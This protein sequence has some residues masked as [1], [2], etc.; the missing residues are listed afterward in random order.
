MKIGSRN[1]I[2]HALLS[3][4]ALVFFILLNRPEVILISGLGSVA[5]YPATG[6]VMALLLAIS[7][8]YA[9]LACLASAL[10]GFL[11]Y[12]QPFTS[13]GATIGAVAFG[14]SYAT[15]AHILRDRVRIDIRLRCRRDVACYLLVTTAAALIATFIGVACL[16]ADRSIPLKE[17]WLAALVWFLGDEI[18][19]LGVAPFLLIHVFPL[20]RRQLSTS[21]RPVELLI[22]KPSIW[23]L[24]E[25][26]IQGLSSGVV[27]W[28]MFGRPFGSLELFYLSF[29]PVIW[30]A[31][32][33]GIRRVVTILV[34]LN[35]GIALAMHFTP[36][37][38]GLL[39]KLGLLMFVISAAGL[40]L[41]SAVTERHRIAAELLERRTELQAVNGQLLI[42]K[43]AAEAA[44][45]AKSE[46]LANL[47]HEIRS[48]INGILGMAELV[49]DTELAP[50]QREYLELLKSSGESLLGV[51]NAILDFSKIEA[52]KLEL[53]AVE[54]NLRDVIDETI[55]SLAIQA[56]QKGLD[57]VYQVDANIQCVVG[58]SGL[59]RQI[60]VN[61]VGNAIK[62]T[63]QGEIVVLA[64][65]EALHDHEVELC[66]RVADTGIGIPLDKQSLIFEAFAQA[67]GSTTRT[68]GGT[69]LGLSI[70]SQLVALMGGRIW[71]ESTVSKGST[72]CFTVRMRTP[73]ATCASGNDDVPEL[74]DLPVLVVD[75]SSASRRITVD[76]C[77]VWGMRASGVGSGLEAL[78]A[79]RDAR[80]SGR[81]FRFVVIDDRM[82]GM[83]GFELAEHLRSDHDLGTVIML[84]TSNSCQAEVKRCQKLGIAAYVRKPI[85][86]SDMLRSILAALA[87]P[88]NQASISTT[89]ASPQK[90]PRTLRVLVAEDNPV[91]QKTVVG[92][93]KKMGHSARVA[94]N[95]QEALALLA[96]EAFDLVLMDVQ[97]PLMD[98][99]TAS[100]LIREHEKGSGS[101]VPIIAM[102]AHAMKTYEQ[103]CLEAGMD[104]YL[105]K[106]AN[107]RQL[108]SAIT[109]VLSKSNAASPGSKTF[110]PAVKTWDA[111]KARAKLGGD[112]TL[113]YEIIELFVE[114]IPKQL[115][116]L[117]QAILYNDSET[118]ER[119][120]HSIKGELGCLEISAASDYAR[121]LEEIGRNGTLGNAASTL[122]ALEAEITAVVAEMRRFRDLEPNSLPQPHLMPFRA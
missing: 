45:D 76:L 80:E 1:V 116:T 122:S 14:A 98:G 49:L 57:L 27:L 99:L 111:E 88:S 46:F 64:Q 121:E 68:Y 82:P 51:I 92:M 16:A 26:T 72:F 101:R 60:L 81:A 15:A 34:G 110:S 5:W 35:F 114:E 41:G 87:H 25:G 78:A 84:L 31:V 65:C 55:R 66:F 71:L 40:I 53:N 20:V 36:M 61:L 83:D 120:A 52:G 103:Q 112:D 23:A 13:W 29:I 117:K 95:G 4:V 47:S 100:R 73:E 74:L 109:T 97:M 54:F 19:L 17:Y 11:I 3:A 86:K 70:S 102:T 50:E 42:A 48:P 59:L 119:I 58:D 2:G 79:L 28:L 67:D 32:R 62:F 105:S 7:P 33:Q 93:L 104:G 12:Q 113:L 107:S 90:L 21:P 22:P 43:I 6:L 75:D 85:K 38:Q 77:K 8:W 30:V 18:G 106:P 69:G 24:L 115:A 44:S 108:E 91:N 9:P 37:S 10:A 118:V 96:N 56:H 94:V 63:Q 39:L 89:A